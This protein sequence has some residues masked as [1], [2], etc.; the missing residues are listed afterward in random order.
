MPERELPLQRIENMAEFIPT[1]EEILF[2]FRKLVEGGKF[3]DRRKLEDEQGIYL[4]EIVL[5]EKDG[6]GTVE[7]QYARKGDYKARGLAGGSAS[8]TAIHIAFFDNDGF[9]ISGHKVAHLTKDNK[10]EVVA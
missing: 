9:P 2:M 5:P 8:E 7:Y 4:W 6:N 3:E 1:P 10:W